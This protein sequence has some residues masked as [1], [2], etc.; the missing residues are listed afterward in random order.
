MG[1]GVGAFLI[2]KSSGNGTTSDEGQGGTVSGGET[3]T[4]SDSTSSPCDKA[5][6]REAIVASRWFLSGVRHVPGNSSTTDVLDQYTI[7]E[8]LCRDLTGD[9][10]QEMVVQLACCTGSSPTPIG[11]FGGE[12]GAWKLLYV[13][14]GVPSRITAAGGHLIERTPAYGPDDALCC[15]STFRFG[16]IAW[17]GARF[18][19]RSDSD[20]TVARSIRADSSGVHTL[21]PLDPQ[22]ASLLDAEKLWGTPSS[23]YPDGTSCSVTWLDLG[24]SIVF[25]NFGAGDSCGP[26]GRIGT[27][28]LLGSLAA[29]AGWHTTDGARPDMTVV[30]LKTVYPAAFSAEGQLV[31]IQGP[32]I[33]GPGGLYAVLATRIDA[34]HSSDMTFSVVAA[35]E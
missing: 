32:N 17:D 28:H 5:S 33:V 34:G 22:T 23:I 35:G 9:G 3:T 30:E 19:Y 27:F 10:S 13:R 1:V 15:P 20:I 25:A 2:G 31:L 14:T 24:V 12:T 18:A 29:E 11:I 16:K 6:A 26:G 8:V 21:G 7:T 4:A